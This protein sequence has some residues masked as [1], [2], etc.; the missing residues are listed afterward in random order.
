M[1]SI[2]FPLLSAAKV[3]EERKPPVYIIPQC[4][5]YEGATQPGKKESPGVDTSGLQLKY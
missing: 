5:D 3:R 1:N 4:I 2:F